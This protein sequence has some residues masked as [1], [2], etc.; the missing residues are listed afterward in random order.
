MARTGYY[1]VNPSP[2]PI[3]AS[4]S[5]LGLCSSFLIFFSQSL[6]FIF[7]VPFS[8]SFGLLAFSMVNWWGDVVTESTFMGEWS[9]YVLRTYVWG[10]RFFIISE[11]FFFGGFLSSF[12]YYSVGE[13]SIQGVGFWPPRGIKPLHPGKTALLNTGVLVWSSF[14]GAWALNAVKV[15]NAVPCDGK[16]YSLG[17]HNGGKEKIVSSL[18][19]QKEALLSLGLTI[20]LGLSFIYLQAQEYYWASYTISDGV[21]GSIFYLL[22]GFHGLHV[23][24]GTIFL[25]VCW[26]RLYLL[27]FSYKHFV[28]GIWAA[29]WYWHFVD[30]VWIFVFSLVYIWGFWGYG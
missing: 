1:I 6:T 30:I 7:W 3:L 10:F 20:F 16:S 8:V 26:F 15:H 29:V 23:I 12:I 4:F 21:Y 5:V 19:Y 9:S 27:H 25:I 11:A 22:T 28:F 17:P 13:C 2:W 18:S 24:I 14:T